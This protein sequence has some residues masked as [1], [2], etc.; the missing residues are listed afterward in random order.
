MKITAKSGYEDRE[1]VKPKRINDEVN[2][3]AESI[4]GVVVTK[5]LIISI[6]IPHLIFKQQ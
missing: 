6:S 4:F 2:N 1:K 5:T 3:T